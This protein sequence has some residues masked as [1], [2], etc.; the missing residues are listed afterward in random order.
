M[1]LGGGKYPL[2]LEYGETYEKAVETGRG[3]S[4]E[5]SEDI[6]RRIEEMFKLIK[7]LHKEIK[8]LH[9]NLENHIKSTNAALDKLKNDEEIIRISKQKG[10]VTCEFCGYDSVMPGDNICG[11]CGKDL[12]PR[13]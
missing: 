6:R 11:S 10:T 4:A 5:D 9:I 3:A 2:I 12:R 7:T 1:M 8:Q 13:S